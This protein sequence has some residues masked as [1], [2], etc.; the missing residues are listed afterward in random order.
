MISFDFDRPT[1]RRRLTAYSAVLLAWMAPAFFGLALAHAATGWAGWLALGLMWVIVTHSIQYA[2]W[3]GAL[4]RGLRR[5]TPAVVVNRDG[6]VD[7]ASPYALG[8]LGWDE[9]E[10]MYPGDWTVRLF[11]G[12]SRRMPVI[13][14]QRGIAVILKDGVDLQRCLVGKPKFVR[15]M[16]RPWYARERGRWLFIPEMMLTVPADEL[17]RQINH[18]YTTQ[19]L[20]PG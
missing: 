15:S 5:K 3:V 12:R 17:M 8:Q 19:V 14:K 4:S 20:G 16:A 2:T 18:F 11:G 9:I 6:I 7:N 10:K 1:M 13:N